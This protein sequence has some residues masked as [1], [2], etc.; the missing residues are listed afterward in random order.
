MVSSSAGI[1][2]PSRGCFH[3]DIE[4][5]L[6]CSYREGRR[7]HLLTS[8]SA[9]SFPT[10]RRQDSLPTMRYMEK[11][12]QLYSPLG[13]YTHLT[14][15]F[16]CLRCDIETRRLLPRSVPSYLAPPP[17]CKEEY[18]PRSFFG[19]LPCTRLVS[20]YCYLILASPLSTPR[21]E[22]LSS[23]GPQCVRRQ[24]LR[25]IFNLNLYGSK[26]RVCE[27]FQVSDL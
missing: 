4:R 15:Y 23:L 16:I 14:Q 12:I 20:Q 6:A 7:Q 26:G 9:L 5:Y 13:D 8:F 19:E 17:R 27:P 10:F 11:T 3:S 1:T 2:P 22:R 21:A 24:R 25:L 18:T